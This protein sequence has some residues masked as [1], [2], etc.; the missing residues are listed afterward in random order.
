MFSI[1]F[2]IITESES[3]SDLSIFVC[4]LYRL[5]HFIIKKQASLQ[6]QIRSGHEVL[7]VSKQTSLLL[8]LSSM[9]FTGEEEPAH[10]KHFIIFRVSSNKTHSRHGADMR[11][12]ELLF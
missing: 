10:E 7:N 2:G 3:L 1:L 12:N 6:S 4:P 11:H 5:P 9:L 8:N